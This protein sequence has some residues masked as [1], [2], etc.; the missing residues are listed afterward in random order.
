MMPLLRALVLGAALIAAPAFAH[1]G[2]DHKVMGVVTAIHGDHVTVKTAAGQ[3]R[4]FEITKA[5][6]ILRGKIV[7]S[8]DQ[9]VVGLR[10]V[11][12][13]G[14]GQEPLRARIVQYAAAGQARR[15]H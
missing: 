9:V 4:T 13:V 5:T 3:E 14:D 8:R 15:T 1:P 11:V 12:N 6:R 2:H 10:L 7:G